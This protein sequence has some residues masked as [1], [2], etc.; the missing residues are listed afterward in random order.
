MSGTFGEQ[1]AIQLSIRD[2]QG[3]QDAVKEFE[4][5]EDP[6]K[7]SDHKRESDLAKC[8]PNVRVHRNQWGNRKC[9][10]SFST[11]GVG[12]EG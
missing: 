8:S 2:M 3:L 7:S 10:F 5:S 9:R 11:C 12:P 1:Q 6:L 4:G